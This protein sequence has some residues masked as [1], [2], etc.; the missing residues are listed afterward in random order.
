MTTNRSTLP[1]PAMTAVEW[2]L[3]S[4]K[5]TRAR[6]DELVEFHGR[7]TFYETDGRLDEL[8][9]SAWDSLLSHQREGEAG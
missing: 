4:G 5:R 6:L 2:F 9:Q 7:G 1:L 8:K 3:A